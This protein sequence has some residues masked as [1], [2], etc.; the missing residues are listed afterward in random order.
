VFGSQLFTVV[1]TGIDTP[2][3]ERDAART[4]PGVYTDQYVL[5]L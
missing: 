3:P 5:W 1:H 2:D 4:A